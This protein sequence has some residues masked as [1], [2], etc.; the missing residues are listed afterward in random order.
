MYPLPAKLDPMTSR[1]VFEALLLLKFLKF[2]AD[3]PWS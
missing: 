2:F 1:R 3:E